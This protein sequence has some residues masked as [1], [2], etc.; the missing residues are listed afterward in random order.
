MHKQSGFDEATPQQISRRADRANPEKHGVPLKKGACQCDPASM[1]AAPGGE[2]RR[3]YPA[4][5]DAKLFRT[6]VES[7]R[8]MMAVVR[9]DRTVAYF[10]AF[11]EELTG[12]PAE[13]ARGADYFERFV[14]EG[15]RAEVE[16]HFARAF[17]S[18]AVVEIEHPLLAKGGTLRWVVCSFRSLGDFPDG[19]AVV[20]TA[21]DITVHKR[22]EEALRHRTHD[23]GERVKE[24]NCLFGLSRLDE[25]PEISLDAVLQGLR[26]CTTGWARS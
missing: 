2:P 13:E 12:Y 6:L 26:S 10:N 20:L 23:L 3:P 1:A 17:G 4:Q 7:C 25:E 8:C 14:P 15:I 16:S 9:L 24:L 22:T 5:P 19:P 11:A 18:D 21:Q